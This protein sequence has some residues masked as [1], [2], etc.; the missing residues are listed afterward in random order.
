MGPVRMIS[1]GHELTTDYDEKTLHELGFK[2]M[3]M[4]FVS[5]GAPRRER[6]GEGVCS[7]PLHVCPH[8]QK[9]K[10]SHA[11]PTTRTSSHHAI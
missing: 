3:Q 1:S 9:E 6:K 2:D 7:S 4:V 11:S 8:P 10:Y 5:L